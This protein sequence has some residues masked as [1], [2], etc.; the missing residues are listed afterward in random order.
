[1]RHETFMIRAIDKVAKMIGCSEE[2]VFVVWS[3]KT[4]KNS[5]AIMSAKVKGAPLIE[6]TMDGTNGVIYFDAYKKIEQQKVFF[7]P[8]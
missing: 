8:K 2:D 4:L 5:K 6:V 1:M 3:A 7:V